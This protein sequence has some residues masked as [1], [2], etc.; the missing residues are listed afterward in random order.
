MQCWIRDKKKRVPQSPLHKDYIGRFQVTSAD[1]M[2]DVIT[3]P[4]THGENNVEMTLVPL[5]TDKGESV[6]F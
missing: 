2:T 3:R 1:P 4:A 5:A 6:L